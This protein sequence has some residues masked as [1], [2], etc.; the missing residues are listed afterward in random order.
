[1]SG[2]TIS[3]EECRMAFK[4]EITIDDKDE[5]GVNFDG[6]ANHF[7]LVGILTSIIDKVLQAA[8]EGNKN[9]PT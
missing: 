6:K 8:D 5:V 1:M 4:L 2:R 7:M 9:E 3:Q